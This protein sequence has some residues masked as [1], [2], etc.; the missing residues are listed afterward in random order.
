ME[1]VL[2]QK[3]YMIPDSYVYEQIENCG[4]STKEA[5]E[6]YVNRSTV[7]KRPKGNSK[8]DVLAVLSDAADI[9]WGTVQ[10]IGRS[11]F[12]FVADG[13]VY[14]VRVVQKRC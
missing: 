11:G 3:R 1:Y 8:A 10:P 5:C 4:L 2:N 14:Q 7:N 6:K 9:A 13:N 12:S